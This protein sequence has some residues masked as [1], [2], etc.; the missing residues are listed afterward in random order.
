VSRFLSQPGRSRK[1][2]APKRAPA[3]WE[4]AYLQSADVHSWVSGLTKNTPTRRP[5]GR[6]IRLKENQTMGKGMDRKKEVK[7]PKKKKA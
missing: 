5:I 3:D 1:I 2:L 6:I 4:T 7:K